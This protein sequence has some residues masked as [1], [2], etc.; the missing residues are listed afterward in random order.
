VSIGPTDTLITPEHA[1]SLIFDPA[2]HFWYFGQKFATLRVVRDYKLGRPDAGKDPHDVAL[3]NQVL[4]ATMWDRAV[5]SY[6][7]MV[8]LPARGPRDALRSVL[9]RTRL[10][11]HVRR[12]RR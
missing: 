8:G 7:S 9:D 4:R 2:N 5:T 12:I 10:L 6:F 1:D 11:G 3:I